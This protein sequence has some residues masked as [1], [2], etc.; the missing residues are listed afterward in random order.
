[1]TYREHA[2][3]PALAP[4]VQCFWQRSGDGGAAVRVV[5]D[6]C[7]DIVWTEG[8]GTRVVGPNTRAFLV[9]L[10]AG[11][12]VAG[13]RLHPGAA[14][15]LLGVDAAALRDGQV[16]VEG[17]WGDDGRR[18][19]E[20]LDARD[21]HA[22]VLLSVLAR[23]AP[24]AASP[25]P[26]VRAAVARLR[27]PELGVA[28]LARELAVSERQ[29]RRRFEAAVGY[30]P[31]RLARVLRLGRALAAAHAGEELGRVAVDAGYADHAHFTHDCRSLAGVAPSTLVR[32]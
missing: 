15:S 9:P 22:H 31:K 3:P 14:P 4:W 32:G 20:T 19:A 26:V 21:D 25:D 18:L 27:S 8:S 17:V 2:P 6:G 7:I 24:A 12:R 16:A 30:G 1:M 10:A 23:R 29:L 11:T 28:A 13:V 5:P